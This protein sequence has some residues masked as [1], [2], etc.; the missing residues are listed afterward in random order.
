MIDSRYLIA[1][2]EWFFNRYGDR[3]FAYM[4]HWVTKS[5][6]IDLQNDRHVD[7]LEILQEDVVV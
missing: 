5:T 4:K 2:Y 3:D 6:L 7:G 1:Y